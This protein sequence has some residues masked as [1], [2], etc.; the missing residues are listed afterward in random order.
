MAKACLDNVLSSGVF[1]T[2]YWTHRIMDWVMWLVPRK[3]M[4]RALLNRIL[5]MK[6]EKNKTN[7]N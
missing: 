3:Y 7:E 2:P 6:E 1:R 4:D 5:M